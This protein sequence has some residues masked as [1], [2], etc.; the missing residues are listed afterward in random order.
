MRIHHWEDLRRIR[1]NVVR[2]GNRS[3]EGLARC[4]DC[5]TYRDRFCDRCHG[6]VSLTPDCFDCHY[7]PT[8]NETGETGGPIASTSP[9][10]P[11]GPSLPGDH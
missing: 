8:S 10:G 1:E 4:K 11:N 3:E 7:Y 5:H 6:A 2:Y 9:S